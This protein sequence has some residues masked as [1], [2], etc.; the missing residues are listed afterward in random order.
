MLGRVLEKIAALSERIAHLYPAKLQYI[1]QYYHGPLH[2]FYFESLQDRKTEN[3]AA[4]AIGE[5]SRWRRGC[6]HIQIYP[7]ISYNFYDVITMGLLLL[8][9][10]VSQGFPTH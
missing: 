10:N 3:S 1:G 4:M 8:F 7:E 2:I 9:D 6:V 5:Y